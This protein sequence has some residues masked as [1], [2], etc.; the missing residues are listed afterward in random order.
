MSIDWPASFCRIVRLSSEAASVWLTQVLAVAVS[1][2]TD[3]WTRQ[4]FVK[5]DQLQGD[6]TQSASR[7]TDASIA[8]IS[9]KAVQTETTAAAA[10]S[11]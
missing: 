10:S 7:E 5:A 11:S 1:A 2:V 9:R 4:A 6:A 8:V 3:L